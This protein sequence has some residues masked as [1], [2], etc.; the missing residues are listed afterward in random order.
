MS[1][2]ISRQEPC[3]QPLVSESQFQIIV[4]N[5]LDGI[6]VIS[7]EG[8]ILFANPAAS[9]MFGRSPEQLNGAPFG[10]PLLN[11]DRAELDIPLSNGQASVVEMRVAETDWGGHHAF[12]TQLRDITERKQMEESLRLASKVF[13]NSTEAIAILD[14]DMQLL[15]ANQA[16]TQ[17]TG[18]LTEELISQVPLT[19]WG[20]D[21]GTIAFQRKFIRELSNK[22]YWQGEVIC[23]GK[24]ERHF[25]GWLSAVAVKDVSQL[26][27]HYVL[28]FSDIS[29][30][31]ANENALRLAA[32]V[33]E[34]AI[35]SIIV[36]DADQKIVS[37]NRAFTK[38]TGYSEVDVL[39]ET[40]RLLKSGRMD[41]SFYQTM[42]TNIDRHGFWQGEIWNRHKSG[43]IYLEWLSIT[44]VRND[45]GT[46]T[47]YIGICS[48]IT[49]RKRQEE[50]VVK[51]A[52]FDPLT[53]LPNRALFNDRLK[54]ALA[55]AERHGQGLG[56]IFID[57]N[58]FKEINDIH[59]HDVGDGVLIES[60]NR[61][62][63]SLRHGETL[64]RLGGDEFVV[65]VETDQVNTLAKVAE[66]LQQ[67]LSIAPI[68]IN[69]YAFSVFMSAGIALFPQDAKNSEE[70]LKCGDI[71]M[72][73]AKQ[74]GGGYCFYRNDMGIGLAKR[75]LIAERLSIAL[76]NDTLQLY[77]QPQ[78]KL[79]TGEL[80][81]AEALLRWD[82]EILGKVDP[83]QFIPI[84]IERG[85][86]LKLGDWVLNTVLKQVQSWQS[87]GLNLPGRI[88]INIST[89]ELESHDFK[90]RLQHALLD[91]PLLELELT[92]GSL[93]NNINELLT[94]LQM[95][96]DYEFS[97]A[98]D[99]FGAGYSSLSNL[100]R[101]PVQ[102]LKID[103]LFVADL[104][105][106]KQNRA[107]VQT[108]I[109]MAQA[110]NME[111]IAEGIENAEQVNVLIAMGCQ[112][113]Q[114]YYYGRPESADLF[115]L[116]LQKIL[117]Q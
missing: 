94:T 25:P 91:A 48:D 66:R 112:Q 69:G 27:T 20:D 72:Y 9:L 86:M 30:R 32:V 75:I 31:K 22:G 50:Y 105:T 90:S 67:S 4:N 93:A 37:V 15:S 52:F 103:K 85:M 45:Q 13:E 54:L 18:F 62:Q 29:A 6:L 43:E 16:F 56:L 12:L 41:K 47:N 88:A 63:A 24:F 42:W 35:E 23:S 21:G 60:A 87:L 57:L 10:F 73:R 44:C 79:I 78:V 8:T 81:G 71:A 11:A 39:G 38:M 102:K 84:A 19:L 55:Q 34:Q 106:E 61:F 14:P 70:L 3:S 40:P 49:E 53:N 114:G 116:R 113:G 117:K 2:I 74:N 36:V 46:I 26:V 109:A 68:I 7:E 80:I 82:D 107:I 1:S 33:F 77:Y 17:L 104:L 110:L 89:Q 28:I 59:G 76:A 95:L 108:I 111:V 65:F 115:A 98:I 92:E 100:S 96:R 64:A 101:F 97:L 5:S 99:D 58:R 83:D 51:L